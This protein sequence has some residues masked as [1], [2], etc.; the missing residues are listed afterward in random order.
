MAEELLRKHCGERVS[1]ESAGI[2][3]GAL[4]PLAIDVLR[5]VGVDIRNKATRSVE[6][7]LKSGVRYTHVITVCDEASAERC[8]VIPG[9]GVRMHWSFEDPSQ[10]QGSWQENLARTRE[11]RQQIEARVLEWCSQHCAS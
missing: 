10:F 8:P 1:V 9:G 3:P 7:V 11:I 2:T 4:N 5:E 6:E